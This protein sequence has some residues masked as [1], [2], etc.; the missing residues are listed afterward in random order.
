MSDNTDE[1]VEADHEATSDADPELLAELKRQAASNQQERSA[2][3]HAS[4]G[5]DVDQDATIDADPELLAELKGQAASEQATRSA[6]NQSEPSASDDTDEADSGLLSELRQQAEHSQSAGTDADHDDS[7]AAEVDS[8]AIANS[9]LAESAAAGR[10]P[11]VVV[12]PEPSDK[13]LDDVESTSTTTVVHD[14]GRSNSA[15]GFVRNARQAAAPNSNVA[16]EA[17]KKRNGLVV[18]V[19]IVLGAQI[20][21]AGAFFT[22]RSLQTEDDPTEE[23]ATDVGGDLEDIVP[24]PIAGGATAVPLDATPTPVP[25]T[26]VWQPINE[27]P[28]TNPFTFAVE[29]IV[30]EPS[31]FDGAAGSTIVPDTSSVLTSPRASGE[32]LVLRV[33]QGEPGDDW[34]QVT[35]P[36]SAD[37]VWVDTSEFSWRSSNTSMQIDLSVNV[38]RIFEGNDILYIGSVASGRLDSP[39]QQIVTWAIETPADSLETGDT[40]PIL[41]LAAVDD[42]ANALVIELTTGSIEQ[43]GY[44]TNGTVQVQ[45]ETAEAISEHLVAGSIVEFVGTPPRPTPTPIPTPTPDPEALSGGNDQ[46]VSPPGNSGSSG[47]P[48]RGTPPDCFRVLERETKPGTCE[49]YQVEISNSC[50]LFGGDAN[51]FDPN[52]PACPEAAP[53]QINS[54]CYKLVGDVPEIPGDC[55]PDSEDVGGEC[56]A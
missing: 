15:S 12:V 26:P 7:A 56:R 4:P 1:P 31:F 38:I 9:D 5:G 29:A 2:T 13:A 27:G 37:P 55:P 8:P 52:A 20:L 39:T 54:R 40:E 18:L 24:T 47:C 6:A 43:D 10:P 34:A 25:P 33:R 49:A 48:D 32:P 17:T 45:P 41:L 35:V 42:D 3:V 30:N 50:Y 28:R 21:A 53:D 19:A 44:V 16:P 23:V 46:L 22:L 14:G 51:T 36:G 11:T